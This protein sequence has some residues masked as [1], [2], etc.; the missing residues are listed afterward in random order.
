MTD[1]RPY[2]M[3]LRDEH[4]ADTRRRIL[5]AAS[6]LFIERGYVG[7]T[8]NGVAEAAGVSVQTIYNLIGGK[9]ALL[10]TTY[11]VT[12]AGDDEPISMADRP[13]T[14]AV[15]E[16][17]DGRACLAAYARMGR[18]LHERLLPLVTIL[19]A[20]VGGGD[21][22]LRHFAKTIESEHATGTK[23]VVDH[24]AERFGLRPG[25]DPS[26]GADVV[27]ALTSPEVTDRLVNR[28]GWSWDRYEQWLATAMADSLLGPAPS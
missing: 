19:L 3:S 1:S 27:W 28:R 6:R 26:T 5:D 7:T 16:A 22:D 4:T 17:S 21:P 14:R 25:L 2:S 12:L 15:F 20:Q 18:V 9:A 23:W 13:I 8:L 10:K 11:D 24:V